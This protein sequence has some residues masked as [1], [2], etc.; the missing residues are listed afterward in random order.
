MSPPFWASVVPLFSTNTPE[1][2]STGV[3]NFMV[4][5]L[6]NPCLGIKLFTL[7]SENPG[8]LEASTSG[9]E[10]IVGNGLLILPPS[11]A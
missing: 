3:W 7:W 1:A 9:Q 5:E 10:W 6:Q 2:L 8:V 4:F 11:E